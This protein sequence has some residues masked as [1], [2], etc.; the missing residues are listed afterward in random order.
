MDQLSQQQQEKIAQEY[1]HKTEEELMLEQM[2]RIKEVHQKKF[3]NFPCNSGISG[4]VFQTGQIYISN[5]AAKETKFID[6]I[7]N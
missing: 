3:M 7:D 4:I 5:N 6:E 2:K 1:A